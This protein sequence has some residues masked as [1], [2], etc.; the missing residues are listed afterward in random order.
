M[1]EIKVNFDNL[2]EEETAELKRL[3][4]KSNTPR[5]KV[6]KPNE[7]EKYYV[8]DANGETCSIKWGGDSYDMG[9]YSI[10]NCFNTKEET[11][12]AFER[13]KI[14]AEL[15]RYADEHNEPINWSRNDYRYCIYY[16]YNRSALWIGCCTTTRDL[17]Q[18]YFSSEE[19]AR[20]AI[21]VVGE[22]RIKKYMFGV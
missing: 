13:L 5:S 17:G 16:Y 21:E 4:D 14:T 11:E 2:T 6:F 7:G 10:G 8:L 20:A 18:I 1:E 3:V 9:C 22:E 12:F 19:I 15:Q